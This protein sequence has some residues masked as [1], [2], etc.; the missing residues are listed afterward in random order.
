MSNPS[1]YLPHLLGPVN[2][3][4]AGVESN[5]ER[6]ETVNLI[7]VTVADDSANERTNLTISASSLG[8]AAA[9]GT[10]LT[11]PSGANL[12]AALTSALP[13]SKVGIFAAAA[14]S[15]YAIDWATADVFT[16]TLAAGANTFTFSNAASGMVK[17]VRVT[18]A[19][20]TLA[21]PGTVK[22]P[23]GVAPTQTASGTDVY[24]FVHDGTDIY[25]SVVQAMA[26]P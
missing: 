5:V 18:G 19:A 23:G 21:W 14:V 6:R 10:W 16:K 12:A 8:F 22:W 25:G 1:G 17:S 24:T 26:A 15:A 13:A 4:V 2:F 9:V 7:G 3:Q 20:S 11:T